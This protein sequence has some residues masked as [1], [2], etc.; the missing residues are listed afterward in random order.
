[1]WLFLGFVSFRREYSVFGFFLLD[2]LSIQ[3]SSIDL[4]KEHHV[5]DL[6]SL[7]SMCPLL[8]VVVVCDNKIVPCRAARVLSIIFIIY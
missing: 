4:F 3:A 6:A 1:M 5:S 2:F 8:N 7:Y